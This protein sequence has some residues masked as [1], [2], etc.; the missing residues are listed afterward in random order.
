VV[1]QWRT[2]EL[3]DSQVEFGEGILLDQSALSMDDVIEH[4]L[5]LT[6]LEPGTEYRYQVCSTDPNDN[7]STCSAEF[8][9]TTLKSAD[10]EPPQLVRGPV[11][12]GLSDVAA[13]LRF[14]SDEFS[15][16]RILYDQSADLE[17]AVDL[18]SANPELTHS[19]TLTRLQPATTYFFSIVLKDAGGNESSLS[20]G[21][22]TTLKGPDTDPPV[23]L[24]GPLAGAITD[25]SA[26]IELITDEDVS[27]VVE[28]QEQGGAG[29]PLVAEQAERLDAHIIALTNLEPGQK[30]SYTTTVTD[31]DGNS[32][33]KSTQT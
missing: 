32:Y 16:S 14:T 21:T 8:S 13:T 17:E 7:P 31:A 27:V 22:F 24:S 19:V 10:I 3:S 26:R 33:Q 5:R 18:W 15:V 6:N 9:F 12:T 28:Y 1:I 4:S 11:A 25:R 20:T 2:D 29:F 30:Y 23:L